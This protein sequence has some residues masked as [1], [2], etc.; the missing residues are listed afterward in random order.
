MTEQYSIPANEM[1]F[2]EFLFKYRGNRIILKWTVV[3]IVIQF[4][5]FKYLY[6][7][8][9][10]IHGDSF[11][12]MIA[13]D[14]NLTINTYLIGYA[15]FLRLFSVFAK[16]DYLLVAFQYLFIQFS[17]LYLLFTLFYFYK[18][19]RVVQLILL[20]F[21]VFNPL[22]LHLGNLV[23]SDCFFLALSATWFALLIWL[24]HRPSNKIIIW[25]AIVL[26][27]AFTVRYNAMIY[28]FI[29]CLAFA[30]SKLS[31]RKKIT[32]I[33]LALLL[34]GWFVGLTMYQYKKLTGHWQYSPFSGWQLANNAMYS[35]RYVDK[36]ER[37]P[38]P[39]KFQALDNMIREFFDSTRDVEKNR[40]EAIMASTFY[41]WSPGMPL[42]VYKDN[43][44]K[45]DTAASDLKKWASMGPLFKEYGIYIIKQYPWHFIRYFMWPNASKYYAPPIEFLESFNSGNAA[46]PEL[47]KQWFGY[48]SPIIKTRMKDLRVWVLD[49]YPFL[50]GIVNILMLF[51]I[52]CYISLK[53]WQYSG[54][55]HKGI[56]MGGA[57][58]LLNAVFTISASSAALRFQS[59]PILLTTIFV[60]LHVDWMIQVM[61]QLKQEGKRL[62]IEK[63]M[64]EAI[65]QGAI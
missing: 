5:V 38:V 57:V 42:M 49:I 61:A 50:S 16:P 30:L 40:T 13:A 53:G 65:P 1:T 3:A 27:V 9:S 15:K 64:E 28:P 34:C 8:A 36:A 60:A 39:K 43:L 14:K 21:M 52:L 31:L 35:Y 11:A 4:A 18:I 44:F 6:P 62:D 29:A 37:K 20:C 24:I 47:A 10:F 33:G 32:G 12:Y 45:R 17:L 41:M 58:W 25:H 26:F 19:G 22:F 46:V 59:F 48:K 7:F 63:Q 55:L 23:S 56:I 54:P 2:K 51:A